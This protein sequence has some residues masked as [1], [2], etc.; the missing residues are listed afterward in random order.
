MVQ[1]PSG[2]KQQLHTGFSLSPAVELQ[3]MY[4]ACTQKRGQTFASA[5]Y[6]IHPN[7]TVPLHQDNKTKGN[8]WAVSSSNMATRSKR[9]LE[10][11][12]SWVWNTWQQEKNCK[13]KLGGRHSWWWPLA[14]GM[15][16]VCRCLDNMLNHP[17]I[18]HTARKSKLDRQESFAKPLTLNSVSCSISYE[19]KGTLSS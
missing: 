15:L 5:L 4:S 19:R 12:L 1:P 18:N 7:I 2:A 9:A 11:V 16:C 10:E 6:W 17:A 13:R 3:V 8:Q 14:R